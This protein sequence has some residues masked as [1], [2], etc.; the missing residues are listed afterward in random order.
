MT[1]QEQVVEVL[2]F[3]GLFEWENTL[4]DNEDDNSDGEKINLS[5]VIG[6]ALLDFGSHIGHCASV[7]LELVDAFVASK[8]KVSDFQV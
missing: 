7:T 8:A 3:T 2:L 6:F 1:G 4:D 5:A